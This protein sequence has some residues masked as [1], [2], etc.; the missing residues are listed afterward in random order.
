[1]AN[2][3][4]GRDFEHRTRRL[5]EDN[6]WWCQRSAGSKGAV[7]LIAVKPGQTLF[8]QCKRRGSLPPGEWNEL[9][10]LA[11]KLGAVPVLAQ[12]RLAPSRVVLHRLVALKEGRGRQ[13]MEEFVIDE[14]TA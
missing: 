7:D 3:A 6:G 1:M 13:P 8:V 2:Y 11:L 10:R 9:Y 12:Q 4:G 14:V 5:L